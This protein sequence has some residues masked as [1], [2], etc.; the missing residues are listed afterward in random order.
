MCGCRVTGCRWE[1]S[2]RAYGI[3][4]SSS[5]PANESGTARPRVT[6][7]SAIGWPR[8]GPLVYTTRGSPDT[9]RGGFSP[10]GYKPRY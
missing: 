10:S 9:H 6:G 3:S 8:G 5:L 4:R 7:E 1:G 2:A